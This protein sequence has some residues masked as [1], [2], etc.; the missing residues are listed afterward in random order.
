MQVDVGQQGRDAPALRRSFI[1]HGA[2]AL[3]QHACVQPFLDVPQDALVCDPVP[4][5]LHQPLVAQ[6]VEEPANVRVEHVAHLSRADA[7]RQGVQRHVRRTLGAEPVR[8]AQ[9]VGLV[10]GIEDPHGGPLD[11]LILQHRHADGSL[12]AV[13][14]RDVNPLDRLGPVTSPGQS[15][16]QVLEMTLQ[17]LPVR[18]PRLP[19]NSRRSVP[20]AG[21]VRF[22]QAVNAV[23]VVPERGELQFSIPA[24]CLP[25]P[26]QRTVQVFVEGLA[27]SYAAL[28]TVPELPE[29]LA[30]LGGTRLCR[31]PRSPW[32]GPFPLAGGRLIR[33]LSPAPRASSSPRSSCSRASTVLW[34]CPTLRR[35]P[36]E[37][38]RMTRGRCD[39][40]S[41]HRKELSSSTPHRLWPAHSQNF[42]FWHSFSHRIVS[43]CIFLP[44]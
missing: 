34:A 9:E 29:L 19:V 23:D 26:I 20:L 7:H 32:P 14:L 24:G 12:S 41:L 27:L 17:F 36:R 42:S 16:G 8:G 43:Y 37:C 28:R 44:Q 22:P 35:H 25:Y 33:S 18:L 11:D 3:F 15:F 10:D 5:E 2:L 31:V 38:R 40:P 30:R 4:D 1:R 39:L 21:Q 13:C 6:R